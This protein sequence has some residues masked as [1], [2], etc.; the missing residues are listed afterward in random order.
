[1]YSFCILVA[2]DEFL[3]KGQQT[4]Y[5]ETVS[6]LARFFRVMEDIH[7]IIYEDK[8]PEYIRFILRHF[9]QQMNERGQ[10]NLTYLCNHY[11]FIN[12]SEPP[13]H[14]QPPA[15]TNATVP[16]TILSQREIDT[17][18][19]ELGQ[20]LLSYAHAGTYTFRRICRMHRDRKEA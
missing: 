3:R 8:D 4:L 11:S 5:K 20:Q 14:Q 19:S 17:V 9:R 15:V 18:E 12:A 10:C 16:L 1:M 6:R 13:F 2:K 7:R